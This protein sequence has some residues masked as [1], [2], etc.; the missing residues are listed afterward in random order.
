MPGP[1]HARL[2]GQAPALST[3]RAGAPV[4]GMAKIVIAGAGSIGCFVGGLLALGGE[5]VVLLAR[6]RIA[7]EI[8]S[9]A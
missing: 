5:E 9:T 4:H 2:S 6:P 1:G 3:A 8:A 7:D